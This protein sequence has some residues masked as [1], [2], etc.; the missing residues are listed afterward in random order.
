[1][2]AEQQRQRA[3]QEQMQQAQVAGDVN[4]KMAKAESLRAEA[5]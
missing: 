4:E 1:M 3:L 2:I 5:G